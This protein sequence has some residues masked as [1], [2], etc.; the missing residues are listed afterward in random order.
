MESLSTVGLIDVVY[1]Y[2]PFSWCGEDGW[3][4]HRIME[5]RVSC[6]KT[7]LRHTGGGGDSPIPNPSPVLDG[8]VGWLEEEL[9]QL[10]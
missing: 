3:I 5:R 10:A 2:Y 9:G 6:K 4:E 7:G 1:Y 8:V